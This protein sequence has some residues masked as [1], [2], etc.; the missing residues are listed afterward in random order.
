VSGSVEAI[1]AAAACHRWVEARR[2]ARRAKATGQEPGVGLLDR[3][4]SVA[5]IAAGEGL[6]AKRA[7]PEMA[8]QRL[9]K[10]RSAPGNGM[11]SAARDPQDLIST[12]TDMNVVPNIRVASRRMAAATKD[13]RGA[14]VS[15]APPLVRKWRRKS[16]K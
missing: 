3:G 6:T 2:V 7:R 5:G 1:P 11:A 10:V 9:E 16:L 4:V 15:A 13:M 8:P 14:Q 12:A